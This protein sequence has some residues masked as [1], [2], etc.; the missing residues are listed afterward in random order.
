MKTDVV[1]PT[2]DNVIPFLK[3]LLASTRLTSLVDLTRS[4]VD[5]IKGLAYNL[6]TSGKELNLWEV[7]STVNSTVKGK[8]NSRLAQ[9]MA[10]FYHNYI[11]D[12]LP[13]NR[14]VV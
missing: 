1:A 6:T 5:V 2:R 12:D 11:E 4:D 10:R 9:L 13:G 8:P 3:K 14:N 7:L